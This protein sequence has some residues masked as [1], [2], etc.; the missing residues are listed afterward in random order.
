MG[1][2][3]KKEQPKLTPEERKAKEEAR[4]ASRARAAANRATV[5]SNSSWTG[6]LPA[7]LLHEHCQ[8]LKWEKV[9]FDPKHTK[10][11]FIVY[12]TLGQKN[13]KTGKVDTVQFA[14]PP[15]LIKPQPTALEARHYA[16]TYTLHRIA[17]HKNL[18]MILPGPHKE[19]WAKLDQ[20]KKDTPSDKVA[21]LYAEDPFQAQRDRKAAQD[22]KRKKMESLTD[23]KREQIQIKRTISEVR[24]NLRQAQSQPGQDTKSPDSSNASSPS[25]A[26][27]PPP[28]KRVRF[29]NVL[30]MS[31]EAQ[32]TVERI[33]RQRNGFHAVIPQKA[34]PDQS[35]VPT[36]TKLGF[37][38]FQAKEAVEY[39]ST[40]TDA[41][42]WLLIH[43]PE[44][45]L[46]AIFSRKNHQHQVTANVQTSDFKTEYLV[47][48]LIP[49]GYSE[50]L[51]RD[52]LTLEQNSKRAALVRL[53]HTLVYGTYTT[54][55]P[56]DQARTVWLE[57]L[58]SLE[59]LYE[60]MIEHNSE[61]DQ[62]TISI[63][64]PNGAKVKLYVWL[65]DDYPASIPGMAV[66]VDSKRKVPRYALL[67][68][69][70]RVGLEADQNYKGDFM[71]S[72]IIEWLTDNV[73]QIIAHPS[74]LSSISGAVSGSSES[75]NVSA[76]DT[77]KE[78]RTSHKQ[79]SR[80]LQYVNK[81]ADEIK[82]EY[83]DKL[84]NSNKLQTMISSRKDLPAW[85]KR[86][87]I[88]SLINNNQVVLITG[89]TGSGK[90]TQ[91]V[92]F[93]LDDLIQKGMGNKC[94]IICTQ[95]RRI[96]AMGLAQR[97]ADER[98][99]EVGK[100]VGYAIRGETKASADSTM[101]RFVTAGVLLRMIQSDPSG[102]LDNVS[103][104]VVDEV[105][106][107]S[108]DSTFLLILLK[109]L[110]KMKNNLKVVLMSAT[111]DTSAFFKYFNDKVGY[112]HIEGRTFP[113]TDIYL[114]DI[115]RET[116]FVPKSLAL[117]DESVT[118]DEVGRIIISLRNGVDYS[119]VAHV[120]DH[121]HSKLSAEKNHQG[122]I[123]VFLSGAAEIDNCIAT[124]KS[125]AKGSQFHALPLH[126]SLTPAEQ[127][128]VF[129]RAPPGKRKIVV[130]T[131]VA[132]TSIT[133]SDAV[134]VID[135]GRV[136]V[137]KYSAESNVVRL[138]D[139]W[140][141]Q[142]EVTQRRGRAGRVQEG[143]CYKLYTRTVQEK[144]M[145][146]QPTPEI[147]RAPLEQ[148]YL[149]VR[150]MGI[151][152]AQRFLG[153]A[154]DPPEAVALDTARDTLVR[155]G[156][157]DGTGALTALGK[158]ISTIPADIKSAKLLILSAVFGCLQKG[159]TIVAILSLR[160]PFVSPRDKREEAKDAMLQFTNGEGDLLA[161]V[162]AY[163][164]F[165]DK[166]KELRSSQVRDWCKENFLSLQTLYDISSSRRQFLA[167][168]EEIGFIPSEKNIPHYYD[169]NHDNDPLVRA[170]ISAA[171]NPNLAEIVFPEKVF[172]SSSVGTIEQDPEA[173]GIKFFTGDDGR[174]FVHPSSSVFGA[175][176]FIGDS[177]YCSFSAKMS[178]SKLF[179]NG[180]TPLGTFGMVFFSDGQIAVDPLGSGVVARN[181]IGL[182]CWPRVGI[183]VKIL[184]ALFNRVLD[185]KFDNPRKSLDGDEVIDAVKML[186]ETEGKGYR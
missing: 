132:E 113:V 181:W 139:S 111:V 151:K 167:S 173:K 107:R 141:S 38:P 172:V 99:S 88:V 7:T 2:K 76:N 35:I 81:S 161:Q 4:E 92:Q 115:I 14:P 117:E 170:V 97:V 153:E 79:K 112:A 37:E 185:E 182:K 105:H 40:L 84:K 100:A 66:Q 47:K 146:A 78:N 103:H 109:R 15:E 137:T 120:V 94:N 11:G 171:M 72:S 133:I 89:E 164:E 145:Q 101:I 17:S 12:T 80:R 168:L 65:P 125:S 60:N 152:D 124:I 3:G 13:P 180:I 71:L 18:R 42:E 143:V 61:H 1:K 73:D 86:D 131:N 85:R 114:D 82:K 58:E 183:L 53:T 19:L 174:V 177:K 39:T 28:P 93:I 155:S 22:E 41:L 57:E 156:A 83:E 122:S 77:A 90:S 68:I 49:F 160:S 20:A 87:E 52:A 176:K 98:D 56:S 25:P 69:I 162:R 158:H 44:D 123:L 110:L 16:A 148:L 157:I 104:V 26:T 59:A 154:I 116:K 21:S 163:E 54:P 136:K 127:R 64:S 102:A 169:A 6:K 74:K 67:D 27:P 75:Q 32:R 128:R 62:I 23:E 121:I 51:I 95:P 126:A 29:N 46:P 45:D 119:L 10:D 50:D 144:D 108:L 5:A 142:A 55:T 178:T 129:D 165:L 135:S 91:V 36:L 70:R 179:I 184:E 166:K 138:E 33:I 149:S 130:C 96:S 24:N 159:L 30:S 134:A 34:S 140:A 31:R 48:D 175:N 150:A 9:V 63:S 186:I 118:S 106:E 8:K 43:V 147:R